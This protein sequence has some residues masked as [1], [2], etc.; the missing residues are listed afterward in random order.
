MKSKIL[1]GVT[2]SWYG[3]TRTNLLL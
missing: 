3:V 1:K 2:K